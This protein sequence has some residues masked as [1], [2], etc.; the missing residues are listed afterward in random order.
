MKSSA[1]TTAAMPNSDKIILRA[2]RHGGL[3][4]LIRTTALVMRVFLADLRI[5]NTSVDNSDNPSGRMLDKVDEVIA[6]DYL[7]H[8]FQQM[9]ISN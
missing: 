1:V 4:K 6:S 2:S 7:V 9:F 5:V 8:N 3:K